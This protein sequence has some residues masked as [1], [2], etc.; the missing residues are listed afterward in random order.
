MKRKQTYHFGAKYELICVTKYTD[1]NFIR[2]NY[3]YWWFF[4]FYQYIAAEKMTETKNWK[5]PILGD[6]FNET[7]LFGS[8]SFQD[9][10]DQ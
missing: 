1:R 9:F 7:Y 3:F 5:D 8:E 6:H 4:A 10:T 2:Y